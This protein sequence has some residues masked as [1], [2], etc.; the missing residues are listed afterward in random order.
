MSTAEW[1]SVLRADRDAESRLIPSL[2]QV[3]GEPFR[4]VLTDHVLK[5]TDFIES[6]LSGLVG[7]N[8]Q[9][10]NGPTRDRYIRSA[11]EEEAITSSQ[12]EG[13]VT[14]RQVAKEML[15]SGRQPR[16]SSERMI[17]SNF[18]AMQRIRELRNEQLTPALVQEIHAIVTD[19]TLNDPLDAG[20]LQEPGEERVAVVSSM[21]N[22]VVHQPPPAEE[23]LERLHRLCDF[24]N[25][26]VNG[27][28]MPGVLRALTLHFMTSY[29][30]YFVDGNGRTARALFYWS[31]LRQGFWLTEYLTISTILHEAPI[32]YGYSFIDT[33]TDNDLTYFFIYHLKVLR[34]AIDGLADYI[35]R[36]TSEQ[37]DI[38]ARLSPASGEFNLRQIA[39]L[40][41]A[42]Q[43]L[44]RL[45]TA[46]EIAHRFAVTQQTGRNDLEDLTR[47]GFLTKTRQGHH[48]LWRAAD[49]L[50]AQLRN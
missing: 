3:N 6:Q 43:D 50:S 14:T 38:R 12:L 17:F 26:D 23:L 2:Q 29:D 10:P 27:P 7:V 1:W 32:Q 22:E 42:S 49:N 11:L 5:E 8:Q 20:R 4:F 35:A 34:R 37:A 19:A 9:I 16:S 44:A 25:G 21:D 41:D 36:T 33:E 31:M 24:A 46:Q 15:R 18:A 13:A 28:Y 39:V 45:F 47:R 30:H 48:Y 40:G